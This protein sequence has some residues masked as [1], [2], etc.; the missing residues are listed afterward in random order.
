MRNSRLLLLA[1]CIAP[2]FTFASM[3]LPCFDHTD[4]LNIHAHSNTPCLPSRS[5]QSRR[6]LI[7]KRQD[8]PQTVTVDSPA[9]GS[10]SSTSQASKANGTSSSSS[11]LFQVDFTCMVTDQSLCSKVDAAF[12]EAGQ[13]ITSSLTLSVPLIV[14]ATFLDFCTNLGLCQSKTGYLTLGGATPARTIPLRDD[15]GSNRF[16]PQALVKQFQFPNPPSFAQYDIQAQFNSEGDFWFESD[17]KSIQPQQSDFLFV[18]LHELIHG[19]GFTSSWEDY[20]NTVPTA[21]TPE[22]VIQQDPTTGA[23]QFAGF[24]EFAFDRYIVIPSL[25]NYPATNVTT[26]LNQFAGGPGAQFANEQAL[27]TA[28]RQS[29]QYGLAK[30]MLYHAT[31]AKDL[32][33]VPLLLTSTSSAETLSVSSAA[34]SSAEESPLAT[35]SVGANNANSKRSIKRHSHRPNQIRDSSSPSTD[36]PSPFPTPLSRAV[37]STSGPFILETS[38]NPLQVGSSISHCDYITY[39]NTSDFLM[40]YLQDRGKTLGQSIHMGGDS[41]LG[42]IGPLLRQTLESLGYASSNNPNPYTPSMAESSHSSI[43]RVDS[44]SSLAIILAV[45]TLL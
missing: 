28:F 25:S 27:Y 6:S 7:N 16:Y 18:I 41:S 5:S 11:N 21:L 39:S 19:L 35:P 43:L 12:T 44:M 32:A 15:D 33:F 40:R 34:L 26:Q 42:P 45:V 31:N 23:V 14:N 8:A 38:L 30:Q 13:I 37:E 36:P 20:I 17:G 3:Q 22:M 24:I 9:L 1:A 2:S 4:P 10:V 29:S